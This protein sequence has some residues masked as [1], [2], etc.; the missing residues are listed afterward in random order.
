MNK[1]ICLFLSL[2]IG[3]I[4]PSQVFASYNQDDISNANNAN[5]P[6]KNSRSHGYKFGSGKCVFDPS[7]NSDERTIAA[8]ECDLVIPK[9]AVVTR[10]VYK[11][12]TTFTSAT[13]AATIAIKV[14]SAND[15]VSA[16]AISTGTT[17]DASTPVL[18]IPVTATANTWITTTVDSPVTF[19]VAS[20]VLTAGKMVVWFEWF[21]YGDI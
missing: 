3:L 16:A 4:V 15:I 11:V 18:G 2:F 17:W 1:F 19:T 6:L 12:L 5:P 21:Y 8:H 20:E 14:A 7:A 9:K 10:A 13:D